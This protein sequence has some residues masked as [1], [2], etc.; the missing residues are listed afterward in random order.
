MQKLDDSH[1]A[2]GPDGACIFPLAADLTAYDMVAGGSSPGLC[3]MEIELRERA[4][5]RR[6]ARELSLDVPQDM[7]DRPLND[8]TSTPPRS[9]FDASNACSGHA[10]AASG[11]LRPTAAARSPRVVAGI[12]APTRWHGNDT[13]LRHTATSGLG[14]APTFSGVAP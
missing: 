1:C 11:R 3:I 14:R 10:A 8:P 13:H 4:D 6:R 12:A 9:A 5:Q 7:L 2:T